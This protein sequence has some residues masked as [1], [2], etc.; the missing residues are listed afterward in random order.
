MIQSLHINEIGD[1]H[2]AQI[3]QT[4][5]PGNRTG[6]F[7]IGFVNR[8]FEIARPDKAAGIHVHRGHCLGLVNDQVTARLQHDLAPQRLFDFFIDIEQIKNRALA[9]VMRELGDRRGH[10]FQPEFLQHLKL[11][12]R[13]YAYGLGEFI[14]HVAQH[15]LQQI[16]ILMQQRFRRQLLRSHFD[17]GPSLAQ[18]IDIFLQLS[19]AGVFA[20]GA[21]NKTAF[22]LVTVRQ[23]DQAAAQGFAFF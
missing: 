23:I 4:Q 20:I 9:F 11:L 1:D 12:V 8:V 2:A 16:Q 6:G 21:Q 22:F 17:L 13:I 10:E 19:I 5:L 3:A 14:H 18:V 15:A 7:Q